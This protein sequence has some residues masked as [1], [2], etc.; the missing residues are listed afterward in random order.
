[1]LEKNYFLLLGVV[2]YTLGLKDVTMN[3]VMTVGSVKKDYGVLDPII[4]V[5]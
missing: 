3:T 4:N 2:N 5:P 1:M